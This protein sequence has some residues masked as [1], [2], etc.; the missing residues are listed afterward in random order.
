MHRRYS[1]GISAHVLYIRVSVTC[2][3]VVIDDIRRWAEERNYLNKNG[4]LIFLDDKAPNNCIGTVT[5]NDYPCFISSWDLP[6]SLQILEEHKQNP[7]I[8]RVY[9]PA[10]DA[11]LMRQVVQTFEAE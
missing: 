4:K 3:D 2:G 10:A 7:N 11:A 6:E 5:K 9:V 1:D 8:D